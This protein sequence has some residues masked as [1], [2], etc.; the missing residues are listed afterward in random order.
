M[1]LGHGDPVGSRGHCRSGPPR[2]SAPAPAWR[3]SAPPGPESSGCRAAVRLLLVSESSLVVPAEACTSPSVAPSSDPPATPPGPTL[4]CL[5]SAPRPPPVPRRC[6]GPV[7][8]REPG[9]RLGTPC[10]R[11]GRS[12]RQAPP[13][14]LRR[15][16]SA[17]S[18]SSLGFPD[19]HQSPHPCPLSKHPEV[20]PRPSTVVTGFV[21]TMGLSDFRPGRRPAAGARVATS[22]P[23]RIS[24]VDPATFAACCSP[25][26]GGSGQ[27]A[28]RRSLARVAFP[29]NR[30]GRHPRLAFRGLLRI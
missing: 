5:R 8:T 29:M 6:C 15:A 24:H 19:S 14:P 12:G 10:R 11:A 27:S 26:P 17:G 16:S 20:R 18:G 2:R 3:R 23:W 7:G 22:H 4:R 30:V 13:S 28:F 21:G 1:H 25:Y 9:C